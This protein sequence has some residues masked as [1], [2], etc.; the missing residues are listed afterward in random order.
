[1]N[2]LET[3]AHPERWPWVLAA[4]AVGALVVAGVAQRARTRRAAVSGDDVPPDRRGV[5]LG[6]VGLLACG[7]ALLDP[8]WGPAE[9]VGAREADV[10]VCLD[11]SRSMLA[12]DVAPSRLAWSLDA[13]ADL[14]DAA[15]GRRLA[16]VA[17]A[18]DARLVVPLTEDASGFVA[19]AEQV[20]PWSVGRGGTDLGGALSVASDALLSV[21]DARPAAVVLVTDGE[22]HDV[23]AARGV[24]ALVDAGVP[25]HTVAVGSPRGAKIPVPGPR[26]ETFVVD[27]RGRD[28]VTR[29]DVGRLAALAA[30]TGGE[31][32]AVE[33]ADDGVLLA[34]LLARVGRRGET[35][36]EPGVD[37]DPTR[38]RPRHAWFV[39][40]ALVAWLAAGER[41]WR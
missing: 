35:S 14:A 7:V 4:V 27:A 1:M 21:P 23:D 15:A 8:R 2:A 37:P 39:A 40:V 24:D 18:G 5:A 13:L 16:L 32:L 26:G 12:R 31:A 38:R 9:P 41:G 20:G 11:V 10:V 3:L 30:R 34:P 25:L 33:G 19:M 36:D 6:V 28:V 29:P 17:F 22:G